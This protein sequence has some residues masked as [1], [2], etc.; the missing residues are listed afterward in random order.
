[1]QCGPPIGKLRARMSD[2]PLQIGDR[3]ITMQ[4][5]GIFTITGRTGRAMEIVSDDGVRL[6]VSEASLRRIYDAP[7]APDADA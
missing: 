4:M 3:V 6:T 2:E 1:M 5:P 7:A